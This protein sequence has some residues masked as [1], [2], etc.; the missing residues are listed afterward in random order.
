MCHTLTRGRHG[1]WALAVTLLLTCGALAETWIQPGADG[2][3]EI[4]GL[5]AARPADVAVLG[6]DQTGL[7][8]GIETSGLAVFPYKNDYG[9]FLAVTW[10][11]AAPYGEIGAPL[12]PVVRKL[13]LAPPGARVSLSAIAGETVTLDGSTFDLPLIVQPR[14]SPIEKVPGARENAPFDLDP[15]AYAINDDYL[16]E[17]AFVQELGICRGQHLWMLEVYPV[18]YNP[19]AQTM[20]LRTRI[21]VDIRFDGGG[22]PSTLT[23]FPGIQKLVLNPEPE[24]LKMRGSRN[25]LVVTPSVFQAQIAPFVAEKEARGFN[26]TT[27]VAASSSASV[28][29]SYIQSLWGGPSAPEYIILVGDTQYIGYFTGGGA[30]SPTTDLPYTCMDGANDW[31]PDITIGRFPADD[32]NELNN[33][34]NKTL[35]YQAGQFADPDYLKRAVFMASNDNYTV[36]EG[37]HNWVIANYMIPNEID[38]LRLYCHTYGATTQ[39][40]R[41]A[42]NEGRFWGVYSGHGSNTSWA[43]G[44]PF[45]Q[46]DVNNLTNV[47]KY[48][49]IMSF[50]CV[51]GSYADD[52]CFMET[53]LIV[54]NKGAVAAWGSS[55][56][57]YWTEDDVLEKRWFD[58]I[59]DEND[60]VP[61]EFGPSFNDARMRYLAQMGSGSTTRR[62]FEMYNLMGDPT[63]KFP[64][65]CSDA[66]TV[67]LDAASY[68]CADGQASVL[69]NDCGLN[70]SDAVVD[71][72]EILVTSDAEPAGET[73]LLTETSPNSAEFVGSLP[74]STTDAPGVLLIAEGNIITAIYQDADNGLGTPVV[75]TDLALV[76]CSPPV[77]L[78]VEAV[79]LQPRAATILIEADETIRGI[80]R[81][82]LS[83]GNLTG[84]ASGGYGNPAAVNLTGLQDDT[85]YY[86]AVIAEDEAGNQTFDDNDGNC[87]I[88]QTPDIPNFFTEQFTTN[89]D[90]DNITLFFTPNG[91]VDFY[92]GCA[93]PITALPTDPAGSTVL[94]MSD[95]DYRQVTLTGGQTVKLYGQ[96]Y[97]TF[98]IGSNGY[99]TFGQGSTDYSETLEEHFAIPRVAGCYDDLHPPSG[100]TISW[101]QLADRAVINYINVPEITT[102]V[103]NTFQI[104]LYFNG[105]IRISYL[106]VNVT[107]GIAGL[108]R[109]T[110]LDPDFFMSDLSAL[111][112]CG[113][114]PPTAS[115]GAASG[116][117]HQDL[118]VTLQADDDG[119]PEPAHLDYLIH[120]LPQH[121]TLFDPATMQAIDD[122]PY[123][124]A[125]GGNQVIY[126]PTGWYIG[127]DSFRFYANDGGTPPE[128]G[129]SNIAVITVTITAP[130]PEPQYLFPLD[131]DPGWAREG[132]WQFGTPL[133]GGTHNYDPAYAHSGNYL[134]GYNI[135]G[136]YSNNMPKYSLTTAALDCSE[137]I[138]TQLRFWRWLGVERSP[139]D[140]ATVEIS[141]NGSDWTVLWANSTTTIADLQWTEMTFDISAVADGQPVVYL[142]WT[143]GPTDSGTTYPGWSL[144]D[145]AIWGVYTGVECPGDLDGDLDIDIGDLAALLANYGSSGASYEDGDLD[146]DGDVDLADL[147]ALLAV[148]GTSCY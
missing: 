130:T 14:Q 85:A 72:V 100:G 52:E 59:F 47:N 19:V 79:D 148:Y 99:V 46:S 20:T 118:I 88:F 114:Q 111:G 108:S 82:G 113:P 75:V 144:D 110:G 115:N 81:Y 145:V 132:L 33:I 124:L 15:A 92:R 48:P 62:Y 50:A 6:F 139:Y 3:L 42:F 25:L 64:G 40:V 68:S 43:D 70:L 116:P 102:L 142:R 120:L 105:D 109:G 95:D 71:T 69:V 63:L 65:S 129:D 8:V 126:R 103:P 140:R 86:Y 117:A 134:F 131:A 127:G 73:V 89:N 45:T 37:T 91:S 66:G 32:V 101:K 106:T 56:N 11:D 27:Y 122:T 83:C 104:E 38:S 80:V 123:M 143:M 138:L 5:E 135:G 97:S 44:P 137:L 74:L 41:N 147:A 28:I 84:A 146:G 23:P 49:M 93:E 51:T 77:I 112:A 9:T 87:Y 26:V 107:D 29:K 78:G 96:S 98:Y 13:F 90:L 30:G 12:L 60:N 54:P 61:M 36:S 7:R 121:G 34:L 76:D 57:S 16:A 141:T 17:P 35:Y 1:L 119:L 94:T 136:D 55:V 22:Q 10:P 39:Q 21:E 24:Y 133:A 125:D 53:W 67:E 31:Y 58:S 18:A 128:G 2:T 4:R